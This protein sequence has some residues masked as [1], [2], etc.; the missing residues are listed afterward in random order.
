MEKICIVERRKKNSREMREAVDHIDVHPVIPDPNAN[1]TDIASYASRHTVGVSGEDAGNPF[2]ATGGAHEMISFH[3]TP[4][5][6]E[7]VRSGYFVQ[8]LQ[9]GMSKAVMLSMDQTKEGQFTVNFRFDT[10]GALRM[11][12]PEQVCDMLQIS[13]S[14]LTKLVRTQTLRSYKMGRLRRF[15]LEDVLEYCANTVEFDQPSP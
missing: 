11:L 3:L 13:K 14:F 12:K 1:V 10:V 4:E 7:F 6:C 8:N 2:A 9:G 15:S 5:Q